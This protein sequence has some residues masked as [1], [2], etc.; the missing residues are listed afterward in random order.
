[1]TIKK[2]IEV[3]EDQSTQKHPAVFV[4]GDAPK[5]DGLK[6]GQEVVRIRWKGD[7]QPGGPMPVQSD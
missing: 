5:P 2:R 1:M 4:W 7:Y 3:L 6:P